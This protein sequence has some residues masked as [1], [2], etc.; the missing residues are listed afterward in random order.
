MDLSAPGVYQKYA[1]RGNGK[2]VLYIQIEKSL[3]GLLI[4]AILLYKH[5]L[6]D[7]EKLG[8]TINLYE[9]YVAQKQ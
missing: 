8:F 1:M 7:L 6:V 2:N 4:S 9:P 3:Y 5:L